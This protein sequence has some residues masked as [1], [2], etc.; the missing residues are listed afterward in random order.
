[1]PA[2]GRLERWSV[3]RTGAGLRFAALPHR[4]AR[5]SIDFVGVLQRLLPTWSIRAND[6]GCLIGELRG[7]ANQQREQAEAVL[8]LLETSV[9]IADQ[10]DA[11]H[12]LRVHDAKDDET[13]NWPHS[14]IGKLVR[15]AK[16][17]DQDWH[18]GDRQTA[19]R[20]ADELRYWIE[21]MPPYADADV[22]VPAPSS[23]PNKTYDLPAFIAERLA[24]SMSRPLV[25]IRSSN[26]APQKNLREKEKLSANQL[27]RCYTVEG[28]V[29]GR[30][31]LVIDDI[32][33]SG[34]TVEAM[35]QVLRA[36]GARAVLSLTATK[37][38]SGCQGLRPST[39]NWPLEA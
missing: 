30:A 4:N 23:N 19:T 36:A 7:A 13:A 39:A 37:A 1:M 17:Y 8:F 25:R 12:A 3:S 22:I 9:T 21:A 14:D 29:R 34:G 20:L 24:A 35:T 11:S 33:E 15:R 38:A 31:V 26:T 6:D 16:S 18:A 2:C 27:A 10:A 5:A 28:D 32:Y